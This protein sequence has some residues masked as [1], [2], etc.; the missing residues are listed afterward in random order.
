[1]TEANGSSIS[2]GDR[3]A[4]ETLI[5]TSVL[6]LAN[7]AAVADI[8]EVIRRNA[9]NVSHADIMAG[10]LNTSVLGDI[11]TAVEQAK[12]NKPFNWNSATPDQIKAY[13]LANGIGPFGHGRDGAT[14]LGGIDRT[15]NGEG[16]ASGHSASIDMGSISSHNYSGTPFA[17]TGLSYE[18]FA[19]LRAQG[20]NDSN[21]IHAAQDT[22][23]NGFDVNNKKVAGA[24]AVLD[25]DDGKRRNERNHLL[26]KFDERLEHD[27]EFQHLKGMRD[28]AQG[29]ERDALEQQMIARGK[30]VSNDC[31]LHNHIE[32]APTPAARKAGETIEGEKIKLKGAIGEYS[33]GNRA[34][35][36]AV[37]KAVTDIRLNPNDAKV[38]Q[39]YAA[40]KQD[41]SRDPKKQLALAKIEEA[42]KKGEQ[43]VAEK[44][45][46]NEAKVA[47]NN[48]QV[49][50][51]DAALD[52]LND[53]ADAPVTRA[54]EA[55]T[56]DRDK[57]AT[58]SADKPATKVAKAQDSKP[59]EKV[60][61]AQAKPPAPGA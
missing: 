1:M 8:D 9:S 39:N 42:V 56:K 22:R 23:V 30:A 13:Q 10:R 54:A 36:D 43:I 16:A 33:H 50:T 46:R 4:A 60:K 7:G 59:Q 17:A 21:I 44:K 29:Q 25:R 24:F 2:Q 41:A 6:A 47:E 26:G 53:R 19:S 28:K 20:F 35:A 37:T 34:Q 18:T 61:V 3:V 52:L 58:A 12:G 51:G 27:E 38:R 40:L 45:D 32:A 5:R 55:S 31:G 57:E 14:R 15:G 49:K 48:A 11:I